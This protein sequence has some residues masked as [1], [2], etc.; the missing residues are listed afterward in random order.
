MNLDQLV[1]R[2]HEILSG[3][4]VGMLNRSDPELDSMLAGLY[5]PSMPA[6]YQTAKNKIMIVGRE[7][8]GWTVLPK[9]ISFT[10]L[11][12]YV[13]RSVTVH[14]KF[15]SGQL[16]IAKRTRGNSFYNFVRDV[17]RTSGSDG[18]VPA[19][20]FCFSWKKSSP[21]SAP[22][23]ILRTIKHFSESLLKLQIDLFKPDLIIFANGSSSVTVR[24]EFFP[25]DGPN[26]VCSRS[27]KYLSE[28]HSVE[29][30]WEFYLN[31]SIRCFRI[32]HPS[33]FAKTAISARKYLLELLP[34][35]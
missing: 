19:N 7:T 11:N 26:K 6:G 22:P 32:Q 20:L 5:L 12:D 34:Q 16:K 29:Q 14:E 8:R 24:R 3:I 4:D 25:I 28:G 18:I 31:D 1:D 17:A 2:Y 35:A 30:L 10:S 9:P 33:S 23:A 13:R 21:A 15:V 27:V